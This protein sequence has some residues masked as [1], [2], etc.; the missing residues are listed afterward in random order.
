MLLFA[1]IHF[2][3]LYV[4]IWSINFLFLILMPHCSLYSLEILQPHI[5]I[6]VFPGSSRNSLEVKF[7]ALSLL[8]SGKEVLD[9]MFL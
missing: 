2:P 9:I 3:W 4:I 6:N 8:V 1:Q 5:T 7:D